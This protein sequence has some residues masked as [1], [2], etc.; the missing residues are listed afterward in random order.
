MHANHT[1]C[2]GWWV[3]ARGAHCLLS[4]YIQLRQTQHTTYYSGTLY[5]GHHWD[6]RFVLY[7]EVS[8]GDCRPRPSYDRGQLCWSK[9]MDHEISCI[10]IYPLDKNQGHIWAGR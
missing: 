4:D 1:Y 10:D 2:A 7:S 5:N 8:G 3:T 6:Q 9:T